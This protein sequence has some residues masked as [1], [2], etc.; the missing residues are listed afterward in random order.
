MKRSIR[1]TILAAILAVATVFGAAAATIAATSVN[2][3]AATKTYTETRYSCVQSG[4][5]ALRTAPYWSDSNIIYQIWTN[6]TELCMT[7]QYSG[8]YGYCYC[9]KAGMYGWVNVKYTYGAGSAPSTSSSTCYASTRYSCVSSGYLALRTAP[10]WSDSNIIYQIWT[11]G[12]KLCM[13][14]QY[15]GDYGYCYCP[16]AGMYGWVNVKYTYS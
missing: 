8:D 9:P 13:T 11:N 12:T 14:G 4:Y 5:L 16:A 2:A 3:E 1:K 7:G 10:Y 6:G 15:S